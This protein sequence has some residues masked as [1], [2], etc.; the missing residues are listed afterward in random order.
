MRKKAMAAACVLFSTLVWFVA[1]TNGKIPDMRVTCLFAEDCLLPCT[2]KPAAEEVIGWSRQEVLVHSF[3]QGSSQL[4]KQHMHYRGRT[5]LFPEQ[6]R[7]GN[8]SLLL[9]LCNT[10]DRGRYHCHVNTTLGGQESFVIAKV[11]APVQSLNLEKT[12]LSGYEEL[13]CSARD[14][15]PAPHVLW[16]TVPP[17]P[18]D[19][20][21]PVTRKMANKNGL[22]SVESKLRKL[23]GKDS[24]IYTYFCTVNSSYDTQ[25]WRASLQERELSSEEGGELIIP[26]LSPTD[27][28]NFTLTWT[29][30]RA[31]KPEDILTFNSQSSLTSNQWAGQA[32]VDHDR[33]LSGDGSLRLQNLQNAEHTG[34]YTCTFSA[35]RSRHMV[36]TSVNISATAAEKLQGEGSYWLW[37]IAIVLATLIV[38]ITVLILCRKKKADRSPASKPAEVATEMQAVPTD[39]KEN[40]FQ[41]E[42]SNLTKDQTDES[43]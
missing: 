21:K 41:S 42:N 31:D 40:V 19:T 13:K 11:E 14:I 7:H 20:L 34:T 22:Y 33:V 6:I 9:R 29:F 3:A 43:S 25:T 24:N 35:A 36:Y 2:F 10:Q 4:D 39:E 15:Y 30:T 18:L 38:L 5:A 26:C 27:L 8:A 37:V 17:E 23:Q 16:F 32:Q 12:R 1:M 28:H